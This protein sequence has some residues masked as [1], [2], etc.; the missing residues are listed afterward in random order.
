MCALHICNNKMLWLK[1]I[2]TNTI[3]RKSRNMSRLSSVDC[4]WLMESKEGD[5]E[6]TVVGEESGRGWKGGGG[7]EREGRFWVRLSQWS[8]RC[9]PHYW[10]RERLDEGNAGD[11]RVAIL[12]AL[13]ADGWEDL[14]E[15]LSQLLPNYLEPAG[16]LA[17]AV[18]SLQSDV[19]GKPQQR[20]YSCNFIVSTCENNSELRFSLAQTMVFFPPRL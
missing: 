9:Y 14:L 11:G 13:E 16:H 2:C 5:L 3:P 18:F 15:A 19:A 12:I 10:A 20:I 6:E 7:G 17:C 4:S 8:P 1:I